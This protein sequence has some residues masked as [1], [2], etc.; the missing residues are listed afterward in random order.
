[1]L[2]SLWRRFRLPTSPLGRDAIAG[3][4]LHDAETVPGATNP[5]IRKWRAETAALKLAVGEPEFENCRPETSAQKPNLRK[6]LSFSKTW[7]LASRDQTG[8]LTTQS[9]ANRSQR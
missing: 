6:C 7:K 4:I 2:G 5:E 8:W 1:M 3:A 9:A